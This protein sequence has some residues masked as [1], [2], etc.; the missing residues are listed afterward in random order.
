M[1]PHV[2]LESI[3]CVVGLV[4]A[5]KCALEFLL[6]FMSDKVLLESSIIRKYFVANLAF[7]L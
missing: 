4:A 2:D 3:L 6:S 7:T 1:G 5:F